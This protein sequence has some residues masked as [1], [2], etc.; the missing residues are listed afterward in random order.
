M[1]TKLL[2]FSITL[3]VSILA[4]CKDEDET[5]HPID[6]NTT[7]IDL[8]QDTNNQF[9]LSGEIN[10]E[11]TL[12]TLQGTGEYANMA[13]VTEVT[14]D[15]VKYEIKENPNYDSS[16]TFEGD[17]GKI[18]NSSAVYPCKMHFEIKPNDSDKERVFYVQIGYGY[19]YR[20][21][22]IKQA[23]K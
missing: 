18:V 8:V 1:K 20:T 19:W 17:W 16:A 23:K 11:G 2:M 15:N 7:G 22:I 10:P 5:F 12:F 4:S 9:K 6:L 13:Y 3:V 21:I 14:I